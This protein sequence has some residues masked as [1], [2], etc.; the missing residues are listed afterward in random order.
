MKALQK[1]ILPALIIL[2]ISMVYLFYFKSDGKLGS[3]SNFDTNNTAV[4]SIKVRVLQERGIN[5]NIFYVSD[6]AGTVVLVQANKIPVGL[7]DAKKVILRGH[8][9]KDSFHAHEVLLD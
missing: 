3:F 8:L 1:I 2:I 5:N 7:K 4:K 9:N 6:N